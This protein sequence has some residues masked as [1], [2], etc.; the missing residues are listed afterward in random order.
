MVHP[1]SLNVLNMAG[2]A[3]S[4]VQISP[5]A[6]YCAHYDTFV[7]LNPCTETVLEIAFW[8]VMRWRKSKIFMNYLREIILPAA[9]NQLDLEHGSVYFI[10]TATVLVRYAGFTI[11]TDPN[12]L[13]K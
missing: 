13:H 5:L 8:P 12:F 11:L 1:L 10:G 7:P 4:K 9:E 6:L 2:F 3:C